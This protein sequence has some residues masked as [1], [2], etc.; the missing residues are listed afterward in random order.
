MA[1]F[2]KT[3]DQEM[4]EAMPVRKIEPASAPAP[5]Q[6]P[7][8]APRARSASVIGPTMEFKGELTADEDLII[9]GLIV[10]TITHH[11]KSLTVG[12]KGRVKANVHANAVVVLGQ[13]V[14]DIHCEGLVSLSKSSD[15][16]GNIYCGRIIMEDGAKFKGTVEM[17]ETQK[18]S[19]VP[20]RPVPVESARG[21][22]HRRAVSQPSNAS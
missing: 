9:E 15:V 5:T 19:V 17:A 10:G 2:K 21:D 22:K 6:A 11:N 20:S 14:G 7:V 13:L 8:V 3:E 4:R 16:V 12:E 1:I 18:A